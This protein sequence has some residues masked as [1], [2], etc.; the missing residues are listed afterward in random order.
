MD[1]R[2]IY[3]D[4]LNKYA[5]KS[6][7][8]LSLSPAEQALVDLWRSNC[9]DRDN[10]V[11]QLSELKWYQIYKDLILLNLLSEK[12]KEW[13]RIFKQLENLGILEKIRRE[14]A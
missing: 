3:Q 14:N 1:I 2:E 12:G 10:L 4:V 11:K 13:D 6:R 7:R 5:A 8:Y 9:E